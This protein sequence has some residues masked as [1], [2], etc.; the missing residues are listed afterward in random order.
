MKRKI[1]EWLSTFPPIST[2]LKISSH[3]NTKIKKVRP[4]HMTEHVQAWIRHR[5]VT[6][7]TPPLDNAIPLEATFNSHLLNKIRTHQSRDGLLQCVYTLYMRS[8]LFLNVRQLKTFFFLLLSKYKNLSVWK[9]SLN[10]DGLQFYNNRKKK[11]R[12]ITLILK[13][14]TD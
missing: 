3:L 9:K 7:L 13:E 6:A 2:K 5:D 10:N 14:L 4:R 12:T 8:S 11:K 1:T